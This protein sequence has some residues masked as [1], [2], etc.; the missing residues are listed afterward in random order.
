MLLCLAPGWDKQRII[1]DSYSK[2]DEEMT[3]VTGFIGDKKIPRTK[4]HKKD[5]LLRR[6][7]YL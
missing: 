6:K 3:I 1:D 5:I 7:E 4:F 2:M